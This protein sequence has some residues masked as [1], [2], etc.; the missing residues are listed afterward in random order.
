MPPLTL[1]LDGLLLEKLEV[2]YLMY[3][4]F[5]KVNHLCSTRTLDL[6]KLMP[7]YQQI[8]PGFAYLSKIDLT[9]LNVNF[10]HLSCS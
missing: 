9:C 3:K 10:S 7:I 8:R 1:M 4:R 2:K 5:T 6:N